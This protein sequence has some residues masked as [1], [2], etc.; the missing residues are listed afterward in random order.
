VSGGAWGEASLA[1]ATAVE[2]YRSVLGDA[3]TVL[4][5]FCALAV[6]AGQDGLGGMARMAWGVRWAL[7]G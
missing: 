4:G 7:R 5:D 2:L 3:R 1:E 6:G